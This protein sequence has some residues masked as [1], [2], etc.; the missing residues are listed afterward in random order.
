MASPQLHAKPRA[1][2]VR[3]PDMPQTAIRFE[4]GQRP[5]AKLQTISITGGLLRVLK[6]LSTGA[7]VEM[8]FSTNA[9]PVLGMAELLSPYSAA[10]IGLQPF[11]FTALDEADRRTLR[12]AIATS[13][14]C[15]RGFRAEL[16]A[17]SSLA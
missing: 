15:V 3:L 5:S 11:R 6:P 8:M 1:L 12:I 13:Q 2:R 9:G 4:D 17:G 10:R 16:A 7:V 14:R